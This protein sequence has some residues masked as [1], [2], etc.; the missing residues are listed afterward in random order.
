MNGQLKNIGEPFDG[1]GRFE[2]RRRG[3]VVKHQHNLIASC[4]RAVPESGESVVGLGASLYAAYVHYHLLFDPN[5]RSLCDI[6]ATL[7]CTE[8]YQ[9]RFSTVWGI[10]VSV[11]GGIWFVCAAFTGYA[12]RVMGTAMRVGFGAAGFLLLLPFQAAAAIGWLN[13]LGALLGVTLAAYE[14][15]R[16]KR[17]VPA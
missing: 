7:S 1:Q 9:S 6:S 8:V 14:R 17:A 2:H 12:F 5:Y 11:F 4:Q 3:G 13:A 10:P 15:N 16:S